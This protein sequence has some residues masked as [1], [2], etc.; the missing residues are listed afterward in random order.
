[1]KLWYT[2]SSEER[3]EVGDLSRQQL[4]NFFTLY[5]NNL[6]IVGLV[7]RVAAKRG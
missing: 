3:E 5:A 7:S 4:A 6:A 1:M 2:R